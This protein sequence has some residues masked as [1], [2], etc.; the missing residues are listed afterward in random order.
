MTTNNVEKGDK[1]SFCDLITLRYVKILQVWQSCGQGTNLRQPDAISGYFAPGQLNMC[2]SL[3]K[4]EN[5]LQT[6]ITAFRC[7]N[8]ENQYFWMPSEKVLEAG[9]HTATLSVHP[10]NFTS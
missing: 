10:F 2:E 8:P 4:T 3:A 7:L 1:T 5:I 9:V 6:F